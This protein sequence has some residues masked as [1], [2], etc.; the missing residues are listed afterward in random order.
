MEHE[1]KLKD[2]IERSKRKKNL[3][4]KVGIVVFVISCTF[5]LCIPRGYK[6]QVTLAPE[7]GNGGTENALTSMASSIGLDIGNTMSTDALSPTIYPEVIGS[8]KFI[9]KLVG[10]KI[11]TRDGIITTYFEYLD[12]YQKS[13]LF[14]KPIGW[15]G[16]L[17][18]QKEASNKNSRIDIF[19]LTK[20][21]YKIFKKIKRNISCDI[22][23][24]TNLIT[25]SVS[26]QDPLVSA[27]IADSVSEKL[28]TF[29]TE[30][31]TNK[32]RNDLKYY[33]ALTTEAKRAY[34]KSRQ[35]YGYYMDTNNDV[36]LQSVKSKID[37]LENDMQLKFNTYSQLN[38]QL[39]AAKAKVQ[40]RTPAFTIVQSASVPIKPTSPKR[41][42]FVITMTLLGLIVTFFIVNKDILI[43]YK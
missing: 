12:K 38:N 6:C 20:K 5:I 40:E 30:Y 23:I 29:I 2:I 4:F 18:K 9:L 16:S 1:I 11:R 26:D 3:F 13:I 41:M 14:L 31:R 21:E 33:Q 27:T 10:T 39:Q 35:T 24:K 34:E 37:D 28:Q 25:I 36:V 15:I 8:N 32:S 7:L 42:A 19:R 43:Q 22:D 17:L